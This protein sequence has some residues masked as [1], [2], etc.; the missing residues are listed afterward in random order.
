MTAITFIIG[1]TLGLAYPYLTKYFTILLDKKESN[2][3]TSK[4]PSKEGS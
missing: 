2:N 4:Q 3:G 1:F